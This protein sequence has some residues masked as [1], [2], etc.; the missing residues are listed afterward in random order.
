MGWNYLSIP[1]LQWCNCEVWEWISNFIPHFI[2]GIITYP[3]WVL[4]WTMLVKGAP[5]IYK[6]VLI[7]M[8]RLTYMTQSHPWLT[9]MCEGST[10]SSGAQLQK[11]QL[12][13]DCHPLRIHNGQKLEDVILTQYPVILY[14]KT[15]GAQLQNRNY[16]AIATL[17]GYRTCQTLEDVIL[18]QG[19]VILLRKEW[20]QISK[21]V[22][23]GKAISLL[24]AEEE[25]CIPRKLWT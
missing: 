4:S 17:C 15:S 12:H 5:V 21:T 19:P 23:Y 11:P 20:F 10:E 2:S 25:G 14:S 6:H 18:T 7:C 3:C 16:I 13:C 9:K 8:M 22:R 24:T 1:K